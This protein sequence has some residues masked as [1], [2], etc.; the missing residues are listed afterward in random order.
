MLLNIYFKIQTFF[1]V[2]SFSI[3]VKSFFFQV[4]S[5]KKCFCFLLWSH[6]AF[7]INSS[8]IFFRTLLTL[9]HSIREGK[10]V[11]S[12]YIKNT[13]K[14]KNDDCMLGLEL[15]F[16]FWMFFFFLFY[17][18]MLGLYEFWSKNHVFSRI[19]YGMYK[20]TSF[21][22]KMYKFFSHFHE[23]KQNPF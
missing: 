17:L 3:R 7:F 12:R 5:T 9:E 2:C 14:K 20:R 18:F 6:F 22:I 13:N 19:S 4:F 8:W 23:K 1:S 16:C 10:K 15:I 11:C 21:I